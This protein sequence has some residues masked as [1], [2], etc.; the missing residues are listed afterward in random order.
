MSDQPPT[1]SPFDRL[2]RAT[3]A[4]LRRYLTRLLGDS[5]EAE[6]VAHDA[7]MRV[8]PTVQ[9]E[10]A[11]KPEAFLYTTARRLAFNKL[12][13]RRIGPF[14]ADAAQPELAASQAPGVVQ[15]VIA[16]QELQRLE[17]A[18]SELPPG[19]RTVLLLRKVE[20]LSHQ[21]IADRLGIAIST[22]EKQHAR[23]LRLLRA[24]LSVSPAT[25]DTASEKE[26]GS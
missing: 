11:D 21:E 6:D 15:T 19:C 26:I 5:A 8:Y 9:K 17:D 12:K 2:Y 24:S 10:A 14:I 1:P 23:A 18:I 7:Y 22:V 25:A 13:R 4:P 3:L 16:R 20:L